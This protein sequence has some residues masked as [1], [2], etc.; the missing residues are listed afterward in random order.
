MNA[1]LKIKIIAALTI[2]LVAAT[3]LAK[4][5]AVSLSVR[6]DKTEVTIGDVVEFIVTA[7]YPEGVNVK[8]PSVGEKLGEFFI[9][10]I[11]LPEPEKSGGKVTEKFEYKITTYLVGDLEIP[12]MEVEYAYTDE[13]GERVEQNLSTDPVTIHVK[14]T[15]PKEAMEI[16]DIKGPVELPMDW[17]P[18]LWWGGGFLLV[19]LIAA[20]AIFYL[21]KLAPSRRE[22]AKLAPPLPAH[23]Q[24]LDELERIRK[25]NLPEEGRYKEFYDLV[26]DALRRYIG[27]RYDFNA[28]DMTTGEIISALNGKLR[29]L[30]IKESIA[31]ILRESDLVKFADHAPPPRRGEE[32]IDECRNIVKETMPGTFGGVSREAS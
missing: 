7:E 21:K 22:A 29:R 17:R 32:L 30:N 20:L 23:E 3:V 24:A 9:R 6:V 8:P 14:R 31:E 15:A 10:D 5:P 2:I 16:R 12:P 18:Y 19:A 25:M 11:N 26:T 13:N 4:E 1:S 27:V 28:I